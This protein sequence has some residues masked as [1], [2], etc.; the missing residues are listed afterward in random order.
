VAP[1][2]VEFDILESGRVSGRRAVMVWGRGNDMVGLVE[3]GVVAGANGWIEVAPDTKATECI[4][5][6]RQLLGGAA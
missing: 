5:A 1:I 4:D 2:D 6:L 3:R